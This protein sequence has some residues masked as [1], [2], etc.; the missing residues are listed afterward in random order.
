MNQKAFNK[1]HNYSRSRPSGVYEGKMWRTSD[2]EI[3]WHLHWWSESDDPDKC[4]GNVRTIK[5]IEGEMSEYKKSLAD[6]DAAEKEIIKVSFGLERQGHIETIERIL[7]Q[8]GSNE[9]AWEKIGK[10]IG[11]CANTAAHHYI[12]YLQNKISTNKFVY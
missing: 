3:T 11:W 7:N 4:S 2:D 8:L 12:K 6:A 5:I 9:Y 10:E 1:I